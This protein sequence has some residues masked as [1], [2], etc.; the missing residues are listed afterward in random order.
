VHRREAE[1]FFILEGEFELMLGEQTFRAGPGVWLHLPPDVP[2]AFRNVGTT[3][4]S[5]LCWV[6]PGNLAGFFNAFKREWPLDQPLPP[7]VTEEDISRLL[8]AAS[9][10]AI[11]ILPPPQHA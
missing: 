2:H 11:E 7:A 8:A 3:L 1:A 4:A 5:M 6:F 9:D 10:Y